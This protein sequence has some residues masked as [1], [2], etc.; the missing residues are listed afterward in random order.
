MYCKLQA[1]YRRQQK[2]DLVDDPRTY[3]MTKNN[4]HRALIEMSRM[5]AQIRRQ[6]QL[7]QNTV[8]DPVMDKLNTLQKNMFKQEA[9]LT[10]EISTKMVG[11]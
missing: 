11:G 10:Q 1:R 4:H 3:V 9:K 8:G 2:L 7:V 5:R 6:Q